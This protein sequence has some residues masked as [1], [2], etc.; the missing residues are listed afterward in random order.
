M[1]RF[2]LK[3]THKAVV[4]YYASL[5]KF[6][7]L[8]VKHESAVRSA[9]AALLEHAAG[10]FDWKLVPEYAVRRKTGKPLKADGAIL[11]HFSLTHGLWEAKDSDDDLEKEIKAKFAAG[12]PKDNIL[13]QEP[14]RAVLYQHGE[15]VID[16]YRVTRDAD[17]EIVS[18]LNRLDDEQY[19]VRL[20]GQVVHVSVETLKTIGKLPELKFP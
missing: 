7:K 6:A 17:G 2:S 18:D 5:A 3:P 14:R 11:D 4:A 20:I 1:S 12:Y 8:G 10:Q 13:F 19:I 15:R 16:Q 9:Y